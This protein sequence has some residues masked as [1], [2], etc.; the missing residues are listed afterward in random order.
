MVAMTREAKW[1]SIR[2]HFEAMAF[3]LGFRKAA[4]RSRISLGTAYN[5]ANGRTTPTE[6]ALHCI[7]EAVERWRPGS[8]SRVER[9]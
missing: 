1:I 3:D 2:P 5:L 4:E 8:I 7:E 9:S 6:S